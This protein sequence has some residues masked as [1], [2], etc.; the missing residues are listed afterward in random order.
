VSDY[1]HGRLFVAGDAAHIHSPAGGQGMNTGIQDAWNL[2]W[3]LGLVCRARAPEILLDT[4]HDERWPVGRY[5]LRFTD[6]LFAIAARALAAGPAAARLRNLTVRTLLPI[7]A[8]SPSLRQRG[9]HRVSQLGIRYRRSRAVREGTPA[10][11]RGPRAGDRLPNLPGVIDGTMTTL[12]EATRAASFH[13]LWCSTGEP[14]REVRTLLA[15]RPIAV[16]HLRPDPAPSTDT[17]L[18][19]LGLEPAESGLYLVRPDGHVAY[20]C[21]GTDTDDLSRY[22]ADWLRVG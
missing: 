15:G 1:R 5:L 13:L 9:F 17:A 22:V 10:L 14:T 2:G 19:G 16:H 12:H 3:K 8:A 18:A 6:R 21:A 20:R 7:V 11:P 4:Y